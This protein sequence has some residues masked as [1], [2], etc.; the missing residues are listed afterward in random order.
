MGR[1]SRSISLLPVFG[2]IM[3]GIVYEQINNHF[4]INNLTSDFQHAYREGHSTATAPSQMT[5][6]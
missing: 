2:K 4:S 6:D 5:D 3:E 1:T